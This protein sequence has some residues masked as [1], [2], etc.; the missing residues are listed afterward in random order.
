MET[1]SGGM[2]AMPRHGLVALLLGG[3]AWCQV[4]NSPPQTTVE[5]PP[6]TPVITINGFCENPSTDKSATT[7][8]ATVI[9]RAEFEKLVDAVQPTMTAR[10]RKE[11]ASNYARALVMS[12]DAVQMGLD[13]SPAFQERMRLARI[14]ILG[15][16]LNKKLMD[17][18]AQISDND[19][20]DYYRKN[21]SEFEQVDLQRMYIPKTPPQRASGTNLSAAEREKRTKTSPEAMKAL[22]DKLRAR[23]IA[24]EDF[25]KLQAD[26]Y[27]AEGIKNL[28]PNVGVEKIRR[29]ALP[30]NH[31]FVMDLKPGEI[32]TVID[33]PTGY[34]L[35]KVKSKETLNLDG[36]SDEIK[37]TLRAQRMAD[38]MKEMQEFATPILNESYFATA[39]PTP[40]PEE[41]AK[42]SSELPGNNP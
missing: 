37:D 21:I 36:V 1:S 34:F 12:E 38:E 8:C 25:N 22:A 13:K 23:A 39:Q 20:A 29:N 27:E 16:A 3:L 7:N 11:F 42:P 30:P 28:A 40:K 33:D 14:Q 2:S 31:V 19:I 10:S 41:S 5:L 26:A 32:S 4:A 15:A 17:K 18:A 24:G 35:Y 9:T 6:A